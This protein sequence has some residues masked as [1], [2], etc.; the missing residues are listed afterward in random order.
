MS[1]GTNSELLTLKLEEIFRMQKEFL[2]AYTSMIDEDYKIL[3]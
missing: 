1:D 2:E 3:I